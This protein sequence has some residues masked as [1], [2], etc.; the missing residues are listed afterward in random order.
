MCTNW[1]IYGSMGTYWVL[2]TMNPRKIV[3]DRIFGCAR[4]Q[5]SWVSAFS[6]PGCPL[7]GAF[8]V[9]SCKVLSLKKKSQPDIL[10]SQ[11][12]WYHVSHVL[13]EGSL[14]RG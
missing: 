2:I 7:L 9:L 3:R 5:H 1:G 6:P 10:N 11:V 8:L 4:G 14:G 12:L 13:Y